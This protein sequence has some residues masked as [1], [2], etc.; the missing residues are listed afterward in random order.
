[1][2]LLNDG[3]VKGCGYNSYGQLGLGNITV[4][5]NIVDIPISNVKKITS[6]GDT[7]IYLLNDNTA[8]GC[9]KN[10]TYSLGVGFVQNVSSITTIPLNNIKDISNVCSYIIYIK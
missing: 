5:K 9:G 3:T 10:S 4:Q 8:K 6:S 2:F 7:N 1:M